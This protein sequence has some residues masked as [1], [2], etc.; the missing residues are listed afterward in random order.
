MAHRSH[1]PTRTDREETASPE[2]TRVLFI[3]ILVAML[4]GLAC[5]VV[6]TAY[7]LLKGSFGA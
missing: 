4:I 6:W 3:A 7:H 5:G 2:L 1:G